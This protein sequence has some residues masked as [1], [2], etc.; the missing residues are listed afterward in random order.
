MINVKPLKEKKI[1]FMI[2]KNEVFLHLGSVRPI[3][4]MESG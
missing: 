1:D 2:F 4:M 3:H